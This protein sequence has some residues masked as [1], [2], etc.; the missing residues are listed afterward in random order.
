MLLHDNMMEYMRDNF[1]KQ[2]DPYLGIFWYDPKQD[3]LFGIVRESPEDMQFNRNGEKTGRLLHRVF[4]QREYHKAKSKGKETRFVGDYTMTP[5]GRIWEKKGE[6][7]AVTVGEWINKYP[8]AKEHILF[9]F[10]LPQN[11]VFIIDEHWNIG[12]GWEGDK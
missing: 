6:G 2:D 3:E 4:W 5:R 11:T 1:D 8:N 9:E 12:S 7:F 10:N